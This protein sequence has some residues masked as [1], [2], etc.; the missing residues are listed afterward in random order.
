M[1]SINEAIHEYMGRGWSTIPIRAG[2]KRP[3]V[4]WE[5]FQHRH[6]SQAEA[7]GWC[8]QWPEAGIG[9]VTGAISGLVVV[10]VDAGHGGDESLEQL[11]REH[12]P[13]PTTLECR[14]GGGG[15]H[16]YFA[17]PGGLVVRN[18]VGLAPG[19]DLRGDGG[20]VVAP[21]SLH[22]SGLRYA[23]LDGRAPGST[24]IMPL[25]DWVLRQAVEEP[26]RRGH[27]IAYWRRLVCDGVAAGE[28][29]NTIASL[30]GHL[31]RHGLDSAIVLE[32]LLCWN[33][34]RCRPPL[35]DE[36][37]ASVVTSIRRLHERDA[38][39]HR[40]PRY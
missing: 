32:L 14:T 23:W 16:L 12:G 33:R 7:R 40:Q 20:Y 17:H 26:A 19:V 8:C 13:L 27:P 22:A 9:V 37:V 3:L 10:D 4:R 36:E 5:E 29:N 1:V 18:K 21:P 30:A 31:F 38:E 34:V 24:A 28:R 35:V 15:R 39:A 11:E 25:P 2:D 6:P